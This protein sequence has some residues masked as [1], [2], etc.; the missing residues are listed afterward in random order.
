MAFLT[1][2]AFGKIRANKWWGIVVFFGVG[3]TIFS[4][5]RAALWSLVF[6]V[7]FL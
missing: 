6:M 7:L 2:I 4:G 5:S 3:L 1:G